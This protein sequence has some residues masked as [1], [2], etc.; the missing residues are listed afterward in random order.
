MKT[1]KM[2]NPWPIAITAWFSLC[3]IGTATFVIYASSQ[4]VDLVRPDYY[5]EE[6]RYQ[7]QINRLNRAQQA[8][9][10]GIRYDAGQNRITLVLPPEHAKRAAS[11][12]IHLFRPSDSRLDRDLALAIDSGGRQNI[13]AGGLPSGLWKVRVEWKA[14]GED[15]LANG[16]VVVGAGHL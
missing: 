2:I 11:G 1:S 12:R 10:V 14:G 7:Q 6:V 3:L 13:S 15:Y 4:R 16:S 9:G 8:G 5:E